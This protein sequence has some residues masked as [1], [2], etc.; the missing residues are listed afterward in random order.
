MIVI[1][2]IAEIAGEDPRAP[3]RLSDLYRRIDRRRALGAVEIAERLGW[4]EVVAE[5]ARKRSVCLTEVGVYALRCI[6]LASAI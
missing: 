6:C 3:V 4:V 5:S 2:V 1:R